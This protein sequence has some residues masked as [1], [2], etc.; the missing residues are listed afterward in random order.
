MTYI[1]RNYLEESSVKYSGSLNSQQAAMA[2][3]CC[4]TKNNPRDRIL[5]VSTIT[6]VV[7]GAIAGEVALPPGGCLLG[8][9]LG[10]LAG[11]GVGKLIIYCLEEMGEL[12]KET[13]YPN[14]VS[15]NSFKKQNRK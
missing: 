6:G 7:L 14:N 8:A 10:A 13:T 15:S 2:D 4:G 3:D 9:P 5:Q 1:K 12:K 11:F